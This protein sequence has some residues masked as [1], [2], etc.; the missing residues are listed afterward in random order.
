[1][2]GN[3]S[4][5]FGGPGGGGGGGGGSTLTVLNFRIGDGGPYTPAAGQPIFNPPGNP[6]AGNNMV[7]MFGAALFV[8]PNADAVTGDLNWS[9]NQLTGQVTLANGN[10]DNNTTYSLW[11]NVASS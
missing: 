11:Y 4:F 8:S 9:F 2:F 7:G 3:H 10:F 5:G 1:M 6:L